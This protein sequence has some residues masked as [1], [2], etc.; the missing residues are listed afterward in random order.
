MLVMICSEATFGASLDSSGCPSDSS[1][2]SP[3]RSTSAWDSECTSNMPNCRST[4]WAPGLT[5]TALSTLS[6]TRNTQLPG[7]IST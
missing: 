2:T 3:A 5:S 1:T 4:T 7:A 6:T